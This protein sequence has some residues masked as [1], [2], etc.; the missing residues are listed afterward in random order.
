MQTS[1]DFYEAARKNFKVKSYDEVFPGCLVLHHG[2]IVQIKDI[3][4][5]AKE[6]VKITC[7]ILENGQSIDNEIMT[8]IDNANRWKT[9]V[10]V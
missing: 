4:F 10:D 9:V 6:K 3:C 1:S 5:V 7:N 2:N 8:F